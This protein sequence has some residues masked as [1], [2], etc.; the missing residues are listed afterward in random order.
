MKRLQRSF[1]EEYTPT[2]AKRL[3]GRILVRRFRGKTLSGKIVEVEAYRGLDDPASHAYGGET[4]RNRV[5][6]GE[7]GHA[8]VYF[9]YG[10]HF[11]LNVTTEK[12][13]VA[14]AVLIRALQ[15]VGGVEIMMKNREKTDLVEL[16]SG[17]GKL[18]RA[19]R[20]DGELNGED[21]VTSRRLFIMTGDEVN[22]KIRETSRI[23]IDEGLEFKW[24]FFIE[25]NQFVSKTKPK[26]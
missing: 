18:T 11:C 6:F 23:G 4:A 1:F 25:G 9:T 15:P 14:G 20:I 10:F 26:G 21:L 5:M 19:L 7:A 22:L 24:R 2:V 3:L 12:V 13:G 16:T 17:P 8:Y